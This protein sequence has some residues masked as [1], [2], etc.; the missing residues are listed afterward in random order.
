[1]SLGSH[2]SEKPGSCQLRTK[3]V[4]ANLASELVA[5]DLDTR[6]DST[7]AGFCGGAH[8]NV[9]VLVWHSHGFVDRGLYLEI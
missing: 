6:A 4:R 2:H 9:S 7:R 3:K 1:M 5:P 8:F